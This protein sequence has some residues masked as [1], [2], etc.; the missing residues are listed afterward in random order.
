MIYF[1]IKRKKDGAFVSGSDFRYYPPHSIMADDYRPPLLIPCDM[2]NVET[3]I[4]RR[5]IN[6]DRYK[7]VRVEI[8]EVEG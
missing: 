4:E 5:R 6:M 2:R 1:A 8:K 7:I 3:E